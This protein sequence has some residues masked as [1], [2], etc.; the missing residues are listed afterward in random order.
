MTGGPFIQPQHVRFFRADP[1][2]TPPETQVSHRRF[3]R[4]GE[5]RFFPAQTLEEKP[6]PTAAP[7][8]GST[9]TQSAP[10]H[11]RRTTE[12]RRSLWNAKQFIDLEASSRLME[13]EFFSRFDC[14]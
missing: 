1:Q 6:T 7:C 14:R 11:L 12:A 4:E 5:L 3:T 10:T 9:I 2:K 13:C 8:L